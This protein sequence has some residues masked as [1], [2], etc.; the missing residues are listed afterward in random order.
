M[1][2]KSYYRKNIANVS[3][4]FNTSVR[5]LC[6]KVMY[7]HDDTAWSRSRGPVANR[8]TFP[9]PDTSQ[10]QKTCSLKIQRRKQGMLWL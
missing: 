3:I 7:V 9:A 6:E 4:P 1:L 8:K 2:K 5:P 10:I